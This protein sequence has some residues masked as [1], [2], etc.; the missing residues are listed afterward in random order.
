MTVFCLFLAPMNYKIEIESKPLVIEFKND[1]RSIKLD[2][3]T[4]KI[5]CFINPNT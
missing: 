4:S 2:I 5:L 3:Y 1:K